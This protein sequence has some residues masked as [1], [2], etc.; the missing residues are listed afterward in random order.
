MRPFL[1]IACTAV[2]SSAASGCFT[3]DVQQ[4]AHTV[5]VITDPPGATVWQTDSTGN[6]KIGKGPTE[7]T[8]SYEV[9]VGRATP[10]CW[11]FAGVSA[12]GT[13]VGVY[14]LMNPTE[15]DPY[16]TGGEPRKNYLPGILTTTMA[17]SLLLTAIPLCIAANSSSGKEVAE[18]G[19]VI[20]LGA[21]AD[22][23][24]DQEITL[25]MPGPQKEIH[26]SLR[27][28]TGSEPAGPGP[29]VATTAEPSTPAPAT[30]NFVS[31]APQPAS[32]ALVIGIEKYRD[33]P[34]PAGARSDAEA[35]ARMARQTLGVPE[36]NIKVA[37]DDHATR[38][39]IE[40][41]IEWLQSNVQPGGRV[42][43]YFSGHGAPDA[44]AGT[45]YL[46][47]YDGDPKFLARTAL[48]LSSVLKGLG[49]T[50]ARDVLAVVDTCFSGAGGRSVLPEGA[51][52]LVRVKDAPV[53][54]RLALFTASSG[55]EI[56][57]PVP[58][59]SGG[60]FTRYLT[61][62]LG[63]GQA[64][65]NGDGQIS[66]QELG[67]WVKPRVTRDAK[68]DNRDQTP[69]VV[70]GSGLKSAGSF[71]IAQGIGH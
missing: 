38:S 70:V 11:I 25:S 7:V 55:A 62:G 19:E 15:S 46:L 29:R 31:G 22:G 18:P 45:P 3:W 56:S 27:P 8:K 58:G 60:L 61:E 32:F 33:V 35:F 69:S 66:L 57:G 10:A 9:R 41:Q 37:I 5:K 26:L 59:G 43:F 63:K 4:R 49:D 1:L 47:P 50:K 20:K 51:R 14:Y 65:G 39:D 42:Y 36:A 34:S 54:P 68:R 21:S 23:F 24:Q 40:K 28:K 67:D 71:I 64:D 6:R 48:P 53:A 12:I 16:V 44:S 2:L 30:G 13:A 52:P 17:G